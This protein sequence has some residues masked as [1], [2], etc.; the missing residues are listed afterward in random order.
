MKFMVNIFTLFYILSLSL[1]YAV[2]QDDFSEEAQDSE[3]FSS[4]FGAVVDS[5]TG[6]SVAGANIIVEGSDAGAAADGDG[7]YSIENVEP[8]VSITASAIGYENLT[9][10]ADSEELN[11]S[12]EQKVLELGALDVIAP[13]A[14]FRETPVAFTDVTKEELELRLGSRDLSMIFNEVPGAYASMLGGGAGDSRVSIRGFDQRNM[15]IMINGVPVND[16]E[17]GWVY[18]SNWDGMADVTSDIQVQRGLGASN[19]A[20]A[21][22]GGTINVRSSAAEMDKGYGFKQ[23]IGNDSFLKSTFR[24]STGLMDNGFAVSALLQRKTGMGYVDGT[25]TDAYSYFFTASKAFGDHA[26]DVTLLGAPQ[27]HGQRDGDNIH[28]ESNWVGFSDYSTN[29]GSE[30]Y[31][32]I[33]TGGSGSGWGY[34]SKENAESIK[35]GTNESIDGLSDA[36]FDGIQHTKEVDGKWIINNRTNYYHK[37][38]YNLNHFWKIDDRMSLSSTLYGSNG[39]GGGTGPLNSRG[40]FLGNEDYGTDG[41][42]SYFKYINPPKDAN[43]MYEWDKLIAWNASDWDGSASAAVGDS[44]YITDEYRSKAIIRASVNHHDWY[45]LISTFKYD[46]VI[47]NLNLTAGVDARSYKGEHYREVV[48]LLGGDYYVDSSD[49]N[50][51]SNADKVKRVGDKVAYHNIGYNSWFGGFLQGEYILNQLTAVVSAAGSNTSYQRE[52]FFNYTDDSG[53]QKSEKADYPGYAIKVGANYNINDNI[54]LFG[55]A[56]ML[57]IAPNFR[58]AYLNYNNTVNPNAKNED[59]SSV[60]FGFGYVNPSLNILGQDLAYKLNINAYNTY[61]QNK[62]LVK[63]ANDLIYNIEGV[64]AV[65]SGVEIESRIGMLDGNLDIYSILSLGNWVWENDVVASVVSDDDRSGPSY[66][67]E[68]YAGGLKVGDAPQLQLVGGL[69]YKTPFGLVINPVFQFFDKHYA[70]YDPA[71]MDTD[72]GNDFLFQIPS[73][74]TLDL[75]MSYNTGELLPVPLNIGLHILNVTDTEYF[76]DYRQGSGGFYGSGT[77]Y[78]LSFGVSF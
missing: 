22:V 6:K 2:A 37:P 29:Y 77:T 9:L 71:D 62:Q 21:S 4:V 7:K 42:V 47:P 15:A 35:M 30:D 20:V 59:I 65:H 69:K 67:V 25:W 31:R 50:D 23:E 26:F 17:N 8:G 49:D 24:A 3:E 53:D 74:S 64:N 33:N 43:G 11:F 57:S 54:N 45:G 41:E 73:Y 1:S 66:D 70:S 13:K 58:S 61:W 36:L 27:Q 39:R 28:N 72:M 32:Q 68:I 19:L 5:K 48:N 18:W 46:Q 40:D 14:K 56:G 75:H 51:A 55:N 16:M 76:A 34:V 52:D 78:N 60:E 63:T 44:D 38:V 10:F 12:L